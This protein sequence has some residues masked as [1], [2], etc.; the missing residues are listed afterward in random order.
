MKGAALESNPPSDTGDAEP[1]AHAE[2]GEVGA[3]VWFRYN[4]TSRSTLQ[5]DPH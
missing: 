3:V 5:P 2:V 1:R 4:Y